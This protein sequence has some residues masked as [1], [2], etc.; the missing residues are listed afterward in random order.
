MDSSPLP[1]RR[2]ETSADR[3]N[4]PSLPVPDSLIE[5]VAERAAELVADRLEARDGS[6]WLR[7]ADAIAAYIDAPTSRVY[8]L[9]ACK[10]QRIPVHRDGSALVAKRSD[11]DGWMRNGGGTRP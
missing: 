9:A 2:S 7:G 4:L 8:A 3:A 11:L 5:V 6:G 10:P 1:A